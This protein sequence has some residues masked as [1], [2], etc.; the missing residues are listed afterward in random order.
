MPC[1]AILSISSYSALGK[2]GTIGKLATRTNLFLSLALSV[3]GKRRKKKEKMFV[4]KMRMRLVLRK[5]SHFVIS[6]IEHMCCVLGERERERESNNA[7]TLN[8]RKE[9]SLFRFR[10]HVAAR[11]SFRYFSVF[12][13]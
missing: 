9:F 13:P 3:G 8:Q 1:H 4:C 10:Y 12:C 2:K 11:S 7:P 6:I 5:I